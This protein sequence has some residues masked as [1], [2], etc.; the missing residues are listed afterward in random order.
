MNASFSYGHVG[1]CRIIF[2][3]TPDTEAYTLKKLVQELI[4]L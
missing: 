3:L 1:A 4:N 2:G